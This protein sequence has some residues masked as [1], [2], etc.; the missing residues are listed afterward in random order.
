MLLDNFESV[1]REN[2]TCV[3]AAHRF[4]AMMCNFNL[5]TIILWRVISVKL[6]TGKKITGFELMIL[7]RE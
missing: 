5:H 7:N 6:N 2:T 3:I 4:V 1:I